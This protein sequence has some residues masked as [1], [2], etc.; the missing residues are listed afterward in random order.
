MTMRYLRYPAVCSPS[1]LANSHFPDFPIQDFGYCEFV[2]CGQNHTARYRRYR[3]LQLRT[4]TPRTSWPTIELRS[5]APMQL[6][7]RGRTALP[8]AAP[9]TSATGVASV[10]SVAKPC[11]RWVSELIRC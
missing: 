5:A 8:H 9:A 3:M 6:R 11:H 4:G 10:A 1:R 7:S 2:L